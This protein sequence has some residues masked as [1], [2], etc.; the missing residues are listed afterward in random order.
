MKKCE[1]TL[2]FEENYVEL[3]EAGWSVSEIAEHYGISTGHAYPVIRDIAKK[4]GVTYESLL[5]QPHSPR[6]AVSSLRTLRRAKH[7]DYSKLEEIR[8]ADAAEWSRVVKGTE[9]I[10]KNWPKMPESL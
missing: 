4:R 3:H 8:I 1:S 5:V 7:V 6:T 9:E 2:R 10:L